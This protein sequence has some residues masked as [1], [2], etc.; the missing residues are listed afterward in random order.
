MSLLD[1]DE[2]VMAEI[3]ETVRKQLYK[4]VHNWAET[5][6]NGLLVSGIS[7]VKIVDRYWEFGNGDT[8]VIWKEDI[9]NA[10]SIYTTHELDSKG[11][12]Q[13]LAYKTSSIKIEWDEESQNWVLLILDPKSPIFIKTMSESVPDYIIFKP[14]KKTK[15]LYFYDCTGRGYDGP[16][17]TADQ[18][19]VVGKSKINIIKYI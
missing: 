14:I 11:C 12:C 16:T 10:N 7:K 17:L 9:R 5:H 6:M 2:K 4:K 8:H 1:K 15:N 3:N 18:I 13:T 19:R